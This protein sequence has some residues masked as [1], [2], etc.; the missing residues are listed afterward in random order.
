MTELKFSEIIPYGHFL[1]N[2]L[3]VFVSYLCSFFLDN[4]NVISKA[5]QISNFKHKYKVEA[6]PVSEAHEAN[7]A[8]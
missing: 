4:F 8:L 5:I 2:L 6:L 3:V 7:D 1:L